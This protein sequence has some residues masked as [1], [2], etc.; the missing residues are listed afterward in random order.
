MAPPEELRA[1]WR[2]PVPPGQDPA[3]AIKRSA[4]SRALI[5]LIPRSVGTN[6]RI[7]ELGSGVGRDL[8]FLTD[9]GFTNVEGVEINAH[10]VDLLRKTYPQLE[11]ATIHVG[12]ANEVLPRLGTDEYELLF[13]V[14]T[15]RHLHPDEPEVFDQMARVARQ[16]LLI[17]PPARANRY[18][19]P[20]DVEEV[21]KARGMSTI[22]TSSLA[23]HGVTGPLR[24][25]TVFHL[26]R[27]DT[28]TTLHDFWRQ[29]EPEGNVPA[30]YIGPVGRSAA[31]LE[32]IS[33]LPHDARILEVGCNVGRNLAY[34]YDHGYTQV[35]GVEIS[36]H[37]VDLL[38]RT[39]PQL[40]SVV[41]HV[42]AAGEVLPRLAAGSFDLV[43]TMAVIEHIHPDESHVFDE[44]VRVADEVLAIEPRNRFS[45][46]QFPHDV[47][48]IF[49]SR[50]MQLV[51]SRPMSDFPSNAS[52]SA[53]KFFTAMRFSRR[54]QTSNVS[55]T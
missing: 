6:A 35:E 11:Q 27:M 30:S 14:G 25:W 38:R 44:M 10:A 26:R 4:R 21:F 32:L 47:P 16:L 20:H 50:G 52:D 39:Y 53:M 23:E 41:V 55:T 19:Y 43:F 8:A 31:L 7:L 54:P 22:A 5:R 33:D 46:R 42:G 12:A 37:A 28:L 36:P 29:A 3:V 51:S 13:T 45:H 18:E 1:F 9:H 15:L 34:L 49:G 48:E 17:E 40:A 2:Q 24:D